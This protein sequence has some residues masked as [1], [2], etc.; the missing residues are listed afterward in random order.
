MKAASS[1]NKADGSKLSKTER[2]Q[3]AKDVMKKSLGKSV[4]TDTELELAIIKGAN[5]AVKSTKSSCIDDYDITDSTSEEDKKN[6]Y[7]DCNTQARKTFIESR[8]YDDVED[9]VDV[10]EKARKEREIEIEYRSAAKQAAYEKALEEMESANEAAME[11]NVDTTTDTYKNGQRVR[12]FKAFELTMDD[13]ETV[14]TTEQINTDNE[15]LLRETAKKKASS[16]LDTCYDVAMTAESSKRKAALA[17]CRKTAL[18]ETQNARVKLGTQMADNEFDAMSKE[19][20]A[21][22]TFETMEAAMKANQAMSER[23]KYDLCKTAL[24]KSLAT[25]EDITDTQVRTYIKRGGAKKVKQVLQ[26]KKAGQSDADTRESVIEALKESMGKPDKTVN[27][28]IVVAVTPADA[29]MFLDNAAVEEVGEAMEACRESGETN[30]ACEKIAEDIITKT[31]TGGS[32]MND[33]QK[34]MKLN[35]FRQKAARKEIS[36]LKEGC[37]SETTDATVCKSTMKAKLKNI[38]GVETVTD[39]QVEKVIIEGR[40]TSFF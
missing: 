3:A 36:A 29:E 35:K 22:K 4:I 26:A 13:G 16:T 5:D 6:A 14:K 7:K 25:D 40:Q 31:I 15:K 34:K 33:K 11:D 8:M 20:A 28:Q 32:H 17:N 12:A 37:L 24:K 23:D 19:I 10:K 30:A 21:E 18:A 9:I 1:Q 2:K 27:G 38:L 39:D